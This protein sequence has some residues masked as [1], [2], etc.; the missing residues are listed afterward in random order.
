[1]NVAVWGGIAAVVAGMVV[2]FGYCLSLR[3]RAKAA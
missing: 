2:T 3:N 1:M